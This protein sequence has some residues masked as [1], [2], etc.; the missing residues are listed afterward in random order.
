[1]AR[2]HEAVL[3]AM[4]AGGQ[5]KVNGQLHLYLFILIILFVSRA[6]NPRALVQFG[7]GV[8][9]LGVWRH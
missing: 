2:K 9:L 8:P 5:S 6:V 4:C 7:V 3:P 1:M